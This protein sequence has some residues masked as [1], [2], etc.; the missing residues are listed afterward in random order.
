[1]NAVKVVVKKDE[2][3]HI[4]IEHSRDLPDLKSIVFQMPTQYQKKSLYRDYVSI[5]ENIRRTDGRIP[6]QVWADA[7]SAATMQKLANEEG[8]TSELRHL[9]QGG[10]LALGD[11]LYKLSAV[12]MVPEMKALAVARKKAREATDQQIK[13]LLESAHASADGILM[14]A[15]KQREEARV[16]LERAKAQAGAIPPVWLFQTGYPFRFNEYNQTWAIQVQINFVITHFDVKYSE[17][18]ENNRSVNLSASWPALP[19]EPKKTRLW[20][21][22]NPDGT[23][24]V[25]GIYVDSQDLQMPHINHGGACMG[26]GSAPK[27]LRNKTDL[28]RLTS[29]IEYANYRVQLDSLYTDM[30][31]ILKQFKEAFPKEL[32]KVLTESSYSGA[33]ELAKKEKADK[34][35]ILKEVVDLNKEARTTWTA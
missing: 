6:F 5:E 25:T 22:I 31:T 4:V 17:Y 16:I 30:N 19:M 14:A 24:T 26:L 15:N 18:D 27:L 23:Y 34:E 9:A 20:V 11:S 13:E 28:S 10:Y 33:R 35:K 12:G 1:M 29:A 7:I 3:G 8:A 2:Q 21:P 32:Y